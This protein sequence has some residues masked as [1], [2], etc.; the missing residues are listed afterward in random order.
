MHTV[1]FLIHLVEY[2]QILVYFIIAFGVLIEGE[3]FLMVT[4]ILSHLGAIDFRIA[5]LCALL[6]AITNTFLGYYVGTLIHDKWHQK[7]LF[8]YMEKRISATMPHFEQKPF[9]SIFISKFIISANRIVVFYAGFKRINFKKYLRAEFGS[10]A[11]W[12]PGLMLLGSFFSYT[13]IHISHEI[14][15]FSAIVLLMILLYIVIDRIVGWAYEIF[16]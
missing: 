8:T 1:N 4:G 6:G 16:E 9:W 10:I 14:S 12:V 11:I 7:K 13:A 3:F 2:H 5:I 15:R